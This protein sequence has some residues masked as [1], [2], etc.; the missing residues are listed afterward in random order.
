MAV[1]QHGAS[2]VRH[3]RAGCIGGGF[4]SSLVSML[5]DVKVALASPCCMHSCQHAFDSSLSW[6]GVEPKVPLASRR[7]GHF[8]LTRQRKVTKGKA[9]PASAPIGLCPIGTLR[10]SPPSGRRTTRP[11]LA[12]DSSPFPAG[13]LCS[14]ALLQGTRFKQE[15]KQQPD[16]R[17]YPVSIAAS[18]LHSLWRAGCALIGAP[19]ARRAG[20]EEARRVGARDR[21]QFAASAGMRC[22]RTPEPDREVA[23]Q[24]LPRTRSGD[25]RRPRHRGALSL[26]YFSL[27]HTKEK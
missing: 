19:M 26:G 15:Q 16:E 18:S 17:R 9:T 8:P 13:R 7:A 5:F 3:W 25:A 21:A 23:G 20:G 11:S 2:A 4:D 14:S 24:S 12:S 10:C 1:V 6:G 27:A 22:Q